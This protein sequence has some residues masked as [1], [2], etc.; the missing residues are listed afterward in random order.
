MTNNEL[1]KYILHYLTEDK[2]N[3]AIMLTGGWGTGK[4][5]YIQHFLKPFLEK[6]ENG[7]HQC[8]VVSLYGLKDT[9]EISKSI[10]LGTRLKFLNSTT[11]KV[12]TAKF[13]GKTIV[14]GFASFLGVDLSINEESLQKL[15]ESVDLSGKLI[16]LEDLERSS[17][18]ILEVLGYVNNLVE[19]DGI[20]V[21]LVANEDEIKEYKTIIEDD[22]G[23]KETAEL[24]D[25]LTNHKN[26][27]LTDETLCY[28]KVKEKTVSDTI[29]FDNNFEYTI[30]NIMSEF[31]DKYFNYFLTNEAEKELLFMLENENIS[32]L[33]TFI[34]ACQ[35]TED[36]LKKTHI[37]VKT[38]AD[39]DFIKTIFYGIVAFSNK[40]KNGEKISW[41]RENDFSIELSCNE[42]PL[43]KFEYDYVINQGFDIELVEKAK[44]TL[45]QL[46]LYDGNKSN[47]DKDLNVLYG[48]YVNNE[49]SVIDAVASITNRL[50]DESDISFYQYGNLAIR[51]IIVKNIIGC[52]IEKAK[53]L[54]IKNLHNK[55]HSINPDHLFAFFLTDNE[56]P[57][58][59]AEYNALKASM[60]DSLAA[61]ELTI[62]EFDY[63]PSS[64]SSFRDKVIE[65]EGEIF[66]NRA[67]ASRL[68]IEKV[69]DMLKYCSSQEI[70]DLREAFSYTYKSS[71]IK[72][73]FSDDKENIKCL[74]EALKE[75]ED[76]E[77]YDK[78][79]KMQIQY[80]IKNISEILN[81]L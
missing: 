27:E 80:F 37:D 46:R 67:F 24:L 40:I 75:L 43:F 68:N 33:R 21:L 41:K 28:L 45:K 79:Q 51:L 65:N 16:V 58:V 81:K 35:K 20:K 26:R 4:S 48:W 54:L 31:D 39:F 9:S 30:K 29:L 76:F 13:A 50:E 47:G 57:E 63:Q 12:T 3:S 15:Y 36:I 61:K 71:N 32:N 14:R 8:V 1:N 73:F 25:R 69:K 38:D 78:I 17:I 23:K 49:Q 5:Y 55:G 56:D 11:E 19:Q 2:T 59:I 53:E 18:D 52:D 74:L 72:E 62:F 64:I 60:I 7:K 44:E 42:Y 77:N 10:Y 34:F 66:G 22:K 70:Q 6:E